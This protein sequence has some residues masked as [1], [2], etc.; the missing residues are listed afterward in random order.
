MTS[1]PVLSPGPDHPITIERNPHRITVLMHPPDALRA[2]MVRADGSLLADSTNALTLR[3][4]NYPPVQ[5]IPR[6]DVDMARLQ[7]SDHASYCP[8]KGDAAYFDIVA[9]GPEGKNAVWT[10]EQPYPAVAEIAGYLAFYP[11]IASIT[12]QAEAAISK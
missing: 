8:Y 11:S 6:G 10:Y 1:R 9:L 4:A 2:E 12:E 5:Y 3:E 7:R